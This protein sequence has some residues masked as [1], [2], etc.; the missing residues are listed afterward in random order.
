MPVSIKYLTDKA[1]MRDACR[2][3]SSDQ[4]EKIHANLR[5]LISECQDD[6]NTRELRR[7][8]ER[9]LDDMRGLMAKAGISMSEFQDALENL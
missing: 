6:R 3:L 8:G 9:T 4:L 5:E 2:T 1:A 7:K